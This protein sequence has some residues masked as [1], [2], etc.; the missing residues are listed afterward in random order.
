MTSTSTYQMNSE[1]R[2]RSPG[3]PHSPHQ[4]YGSQIESKE[5]D[6][7]ISQ[8][9]A[10]IF[11]LEQREKDY[12]TL[13]QRVAKL[14]NEIC[15]E[16]QEKLRLE[17][18]LK[19]KE[20]CYNKTLCNLS[21]DNENLQISYSEKMNENK[22]LFKNNDCLEKEIEIKECEICELNKK[23]N[24]LLG[25]IKNIDNQRLN[26][27]KTVDTLN[28][29]K[30]DQGVKICKL[31]EDN[32]K[33]TQVC[34]NQ[35]NAKNLGNYEKQNLLKQLD[36]NNFNINNLNAKINECI[37][38]ESCLEDNIKNVNNQNLELQAVLKD[39]E[40]QFNLCKNENDNV[41]NNIL[42]ERSLRAD[43]AKKC[44]QLNNV[45]NSR[46]AQINK[47]NLDKENMQKLL[48]MSS[49]QN[50]ETQNV[51]D[52]LKNHIDNLTVQNQNLMDEIENVIKDDEKMKNIM[53]RKDRIFGTLR[54]NTSVVDKIRG[55]ICCE[56]NECNNGSVD[57]MSLGNSRIIYN[58]PS[59]CHYHIAEQ[60]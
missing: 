59:H 37:Q 18:E 32:K 46:N 13:E 39:Y 43:V 29:T 14:Q 53:N 48:E 12:N 31:I 8:L 35:E 3:S 11:E 41:K 16:K 60:D 1:K 23:V 58:S 40:K 57:R 49:N 5:K 19:N 24:E 42:K 7:L 2:C 4:N 45:L 27:Q 26:L 9:K 22:N 51:N 47:L 10:H 30:N 25:Q 21:S 17:C 34:Q 50:C 36:Q 15:L 55:N 54:N 52:Q 6:M 44:E 33:L 20:D 28:A 56:V 38:N